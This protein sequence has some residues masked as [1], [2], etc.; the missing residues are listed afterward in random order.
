MFRFAHEIERELIDAGL[1]VDDA[2][3]LAKLARPAV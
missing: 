2:Q 3:Q 1:P